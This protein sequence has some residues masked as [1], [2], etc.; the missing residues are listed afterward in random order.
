MRG[1]IIFKRGIIIGIVVLV[2]I[3]FSKEIFMQKEQEITL[4]EML[5]DYVKDYKIEEQ[6]DDGS[7]IIKLK[8]PDFCGIIIRMSDDIDYQDISLKD[9]ANAVNNNP[10]LVKDYIISVEKINEE[11]IEKAFLSQISYELIIHAIEES[12]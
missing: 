9:L 1:K 5:Q 3:Y 6:L 10:E 2:C 8:A 4:S 12:L 11:S 7:A